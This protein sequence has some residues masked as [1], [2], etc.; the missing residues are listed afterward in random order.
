MGIVG[1]MTREEQND[2]FAFFNNI[3]EKD[4]KTIADKGLITMVEPKEVIDNLPEKQ[5]D[6][7]KKKIMDVMEI[8]CTVN[9]KVG[10]EEIYMLNKTLRDYGLQL[11]KGFCKMELSLAITDS[12]CR[13][14]ATDVGYVE[15]LERA[16]KELFPSDI[17]DY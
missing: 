13:D 17:L 1:R 2:Y 5:I 7:M 14:L 11:K 6:E 12:V 4:Y 8:A 9:K 3:V 15:N 10:A 16:F